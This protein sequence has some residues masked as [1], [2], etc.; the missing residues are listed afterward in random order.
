MECCQPNY[1]AQQEVQGPTPTPS[2]SK[3]LPNPIPTLWGGRGLPGTPTD[4]IL[5]G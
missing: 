3:A 5:S 1:T 4:S 2:T